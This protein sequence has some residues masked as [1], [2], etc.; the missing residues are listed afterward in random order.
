MMKKWILA[1]LLGLQLIAV[2]AHAMGSAPS[3]IREVTKIL[4]TE[5][6]ASYSVC[7][8]GFHFFFF[9]TPYSKAEDEAQDRSSQ[10]A[11]DKC[12]NELGGKYADESTVTTGCTPLPGYWGPCGF[13]CKAVTYGKCKFEEVGRDPRV[14]D[15][16]GFVRKMSADGRDYLIDSD[17][18]AHPIAKTKSSSARD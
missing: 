7:E 1:C 6:E 9:S 5:D 10:K 18:V 8:G 11:K 3:H 12:E 17:G 2:S 4:R 13:Q 16:T 14:S 15:E